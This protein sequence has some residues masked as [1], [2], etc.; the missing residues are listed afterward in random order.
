MTAITGKRDVHRSKIL[1]IGWQRIV[2]RWKSYR[3]LA[4]RLVV[5]RFVIIA[6]DSLN[7]IG[8]QS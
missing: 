7:D 8:C 1:E 6:P 5:D 4:E 3:D 2:E